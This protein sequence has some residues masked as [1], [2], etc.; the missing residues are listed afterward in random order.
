M[1]EWFQETALSGSLILALPVA[2]VAGLISFFSPCVI[3]LLRVHVADA[4]TPWVGPTLAASRD[5]TVMVSGKV[6]LISSSSVVTI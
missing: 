6:R 5:C 1:S 2:L 4:W 3:P